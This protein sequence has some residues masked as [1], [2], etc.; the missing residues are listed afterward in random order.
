[1]VTVFKDRVQA[2]HLVVDK[3]DLDIFLGEF[4]AFNKVIDRFALSDL[5]L[6]AVSKIADIPFSQGG[7]AFKINFHGVSPLEIFVSDGLLQAFAIP[8]SIK[9]LGIA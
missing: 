4:K 3:D 8:V 9:D 2:G 6:N 1:L 5:V 7:K